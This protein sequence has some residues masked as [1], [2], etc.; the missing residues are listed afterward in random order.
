VHNGKVGL[1]LATASLLFLSMTL[2]DLSV[3]FYFVSSFG[4]FLGDFYFFGAFQAGAFPR[5]FLWRL[6]RETRDKA[7]AAALDN[8]IVVIAGG[9]SKEVQA[10]RAVGLVGGRCRCQDFWEHCS[11]M[12]CAWQ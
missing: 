5:A 2:S 12:C 7:A 8:S 9:I 3:S 1:P 10:R 6:Q 4:A 11:G